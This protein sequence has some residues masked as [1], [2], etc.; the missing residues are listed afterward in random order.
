MT[1]DFLLFDASDEES[2]ACSFDAMASALPAQMPALVR[3]V[4]AVLGWAWGEFGAPSAGEGEWDF[5]LQAQD[6][7]DQPLAIAYEPGRGLRAAP[8]APGRRTTIA[9]TLSG[10]RAFADAFMQAFNPA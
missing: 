2:G 1:L 3:E 10:T 7:E 6:D 5:D 8:Q 4:E 9:L